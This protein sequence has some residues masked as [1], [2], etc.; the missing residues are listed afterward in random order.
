MAFERFISAQNLHLHA[1]CDRFDQYRGVSP[2]ASAYNEIRDVYEGMSLH[3]VQAKVAGLFGLKV[4]RSADLAMGHV[5]GGTDENGDED[6]S[7]YSVNFGSGPIFLDMEPGDDAAF[8]DNSNPAANM[9]DFWKFV[10]LVALKALDIPYGL[11]DESAANFFGNKTA[12][13][14]YDR[15]CEAKRHRVQCL[16]NRITQFKMLVAIRNGRLRPPRTINGDR[17]WAW[18]PRKMPWWR[19]LEEVTASLKA[20]E[21]GLTTPQQVCAENDQGDWYKNVD[22]IARAIAYAKSKNVSLSFAVS[23]QLAGQVFDARK[24]TPDQGGDDKKDDD[25]KEDDDE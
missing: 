3:L 14:S 15:A 22:E 8:L 2:L 13:L 19:P 11:F 17:P 1:Y 12:W 18:L 9:Q 23:E 25:G 6:R 5:S 24:S 10:S 21:G 4:T 16:L 7:S 20:I